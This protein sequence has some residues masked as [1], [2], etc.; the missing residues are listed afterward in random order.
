MCVITVI[1]VIHIAL[2][3]AFQSYKTIGVKQYG[4]VIVDDYTRF[5]WVLFFRTKDSAFE[6]FEKLIKVLENKL[7]TRLAGIRS[8]RGGEFKKEFVT[9]CEARGITHEF[10]TPRTPQQNGVVQYVS[11]L[12]L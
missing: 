8:D 7:D 11:Q 5:T 10:S 12:S 6:E 2:Q 9:Y 3:Y 4:F 1:L